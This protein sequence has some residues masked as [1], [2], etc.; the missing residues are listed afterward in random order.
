MIFC[1]PIIRDLQ[2]EMKNLYGNGIVHVKKDSSLHAV[3]KINFR[4]HF[5]QNDREPIFFYLPC[6][7]PEAKLFYSI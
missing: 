4:Q 5:V 6:S 1:V 2:N 7:K 3:T